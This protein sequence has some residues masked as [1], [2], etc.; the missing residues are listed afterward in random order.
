MGRGPHG[1][2]ALHLSCCRYPPTPVIRA[3]LDAAP[4]ITALPNGDGE[5]SL[6]LALG[7]ASEEV[8]LLLI[9][10]SLEAIFKVDNNG[11]TPLHLAVISG[12]SRRVLLTLIQFNPL[13][14]LQP[15]HNSR[16]PSDNLRRSYVHATTLEDIICSSTESPDE[17]FF[18]DDWNKAL[19]FLLSAASLIYGFTLPL[20]NPLEKSNNND[21]LARMELCHYISPFRS[22]YKCVPL[23]IATWIN[24]PRS[25][26]KTLTTWYPDQ[27]LAVDSFGNTPLCLAASAPLWNYTGDFVDE[28]D[29]PEEEDDD[30]CELQKD[31]SVVQILLSANPSA[32]SIPNT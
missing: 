28:L 20:N 29:D 30:D 5:T 24:C 2:T 15:N 4:G 8:Q 14:V 16:T 22:S 23:H 12:A 18:R 7:S 1:Q 6:H 13:A 19:L 26:T 32:A 17:F 27:C 10:D 31:E 21:C 11:D 9:Q 25:V 3:I